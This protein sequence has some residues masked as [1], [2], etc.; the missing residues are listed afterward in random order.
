MEKQDCL[1][2]R[3]ARKEIPSK[4]VLEDSSVLAFEDVNPQ[5]PVHVLLIP[6]EHIE[7]ISGL[8]ERHI[9][10]VGRLILAAKDIASRKGVQESGYRIVMN[11]N[12][13]AGQAVFHLHLHLLGGRKFSWPPG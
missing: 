13:D 6:K 1:F 12:R 10:L 7:K 9:E 2:C 3:I 11:C 4:I 8:S 5:A